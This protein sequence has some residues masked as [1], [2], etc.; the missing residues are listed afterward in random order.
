MGFI[1]QTRDF[2]SEVRVESTK[3]SW[4]SRNEV[5]DST[6]V[7]IISVILIAAFVGVVDRILTFGIGLLFR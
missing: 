7:V 6:V 2:V 3:V 1:E 5:R 4:P